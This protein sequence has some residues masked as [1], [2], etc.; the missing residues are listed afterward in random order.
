[1][2]LDKLINSINKKYGVNSINKLSD[3]SNVDVESISTGSLGLDIALG[4]GGF[5]KGRFIEIIGPESSGKTTIAL[6]AIAQAQKQNI[7]CAFLDVEHAFDP[8][9]ANALGINNE[10]LL[11]AQPDNGEQVV[12]IA[13][14]CAKSGE[15][16]LIVIDSVAA[17][18][19]QAELQ[20]EAGD[21]K[22]GLHAR[23]MSQACKKL[24]GVCQKNNVM[25]IWINQLRH[26]I[27][28]MFGS[29]ETTPGGNSLKYYASVRLD[30]R[31]SGA[32]SK[33]R[34][35]EKIASPTKVKVIKSKVGRP[36]KEAIFDIYY[37]E[38]ISLAGE[39]LELGVA[40]DL[41]QK[42]GAWYSYDGTK[43]GQGKVKCIDFLNDNE[44]LLQEL[45]NILINQYLNQ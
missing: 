27:G 7:T 28:V 20:A 13:E 32:A 6:H 4:I 26:K 9:Y 21:Q 25:V 41:I 12:S 31:R 23:L 40:C 5:P 43:I 29:P 24:T 35:G 42:Q 10:L 14:D 38:G 18:I 8:E 44:D 22:L 16:G 33:N 37:G 3:Q 19:P 11:F 39:V 15:V 36:F 45:R 34:E 17:M 1:M 30:V 2:S